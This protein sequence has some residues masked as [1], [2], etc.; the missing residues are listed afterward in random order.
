MLT[1]IRRS[2]LDYLPFNLST[3]TRNYSS[4][5]CSICQTVLLP[6]IYI[7][8]NHNDLSTTTSIRFYFSPVVST[9][10][11]SL[12]PLERLGFPSDRGA[13]PDTCENSVDDLRFAE[14]WQM[15]F[16]SFSGVQPAPDEKNS[17][18]G[19]LFD[20]TMEFIHMCALSSER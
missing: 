5:T 11:A 16:R 4:S 1:I 12:K 10:I 7:H 3:T 9:Q 19:P 17:Y 14:R 13:R 8:F 20:K 2:Y 6:S 18:G 15:A